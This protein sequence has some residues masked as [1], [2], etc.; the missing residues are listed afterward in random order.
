MI[1]HDFKGGIGTSSRLVETPYGTYTLGVLVQTNHGDRNDLRVNGYPV[2][3][4]INKEV[5]PLP[6]ED[7]QSG[8]SII[9]IIATDA[10]LI[11]CQCKRLAHRAA[12][13]TGKV[14]GI[15]HNG[16]GDIFLAFST[17]NHIPVEIENLMSL[18]MIPHHNLNPFFY[19]VI[20]TVEESILNSLTAAQTITGYHGRTAY[21]LP[22]NQLQ[23]MLKHWEG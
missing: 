8:G 19:A 3:K 11:S 17:G 13:G 16:S 6:W 22:G 15:G 10:P 4:K 5:V 14:G 20:E 2:G 18:Q 9:V 7:S 23:S 1:C 21:E 12:I